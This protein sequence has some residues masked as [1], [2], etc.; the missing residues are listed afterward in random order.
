[1][2]SAEERIME[3]R[4]VSVRTN[5]RNPRLLMPLLAFS[6]FLLL[7]AMS[8]TKSVYAAGTVPPPQSF[9]PGD[10]GG[11]YTILPH[12]IYGHVHSTLDGSSVVGLE[13]WLY[14]GSFW[15][16]TTNTTG[17]FMFQSGPQILANSRYM[18]SLNG[19]MDTISWDS[20]IPNPDWC[21]W[22]GYVQTDRYACAFAPLP[23][24]PKAT[25]NVTAA[26]L[27]S[28]TKYATLYYSTTETHTF[29]HTDTFKLAG[30]G[31]TTI[32][33]QSVIVTGSCWADPSH[34]IKY[35]RPYYSTACLDATQDPPKVVKA[36]LIGEVRY[37][38]WG[39][40]AVPEYLNPS[41]LT[42][43]Y[44]D[45][46]V[47]AGS[48]VT[49]VYRETNS[50][51]WSQTGGSSLAIKYSIL[52]FQVDLT[53][54]VTSTTE[55]ANEVTCEVHNTGNVALWFRMYTAGFTFSLDPRD[56]RKNL[57]GME[58]H[59]WDMSGAG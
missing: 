20:Y 57:G 31:V 56:P 58:L 42:E 23:M 8:A 52:G 34:C 5:A 9:T 14:D 4:K 16:T 49:K 15:Y 47:A 7:F 21:Q 40:A 6:F 28:N 35:Y 19:R 46:D 1:M 10:G 33:T 17:W 37:H 45:F 32:G 18:L 3:I 48:G 12:T 25:V 2:Y 53:T 50:T 54:T 38:D 36:G 11:G 43:D 26:A 22:V 51:T 41:T 39:T 55:Y 29:T 44:V 59:I 27:F 30:S 24:D 13:V